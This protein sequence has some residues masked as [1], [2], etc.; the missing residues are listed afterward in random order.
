M[1]YFIAEDPSL[2]EIEAIDDLNPVPEGTADPM[3]IDEFLKV[4]T[5][6]EELIGEE[7]MH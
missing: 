7:Y 5:E 2:P 6:V 3:D 1:V 4:G